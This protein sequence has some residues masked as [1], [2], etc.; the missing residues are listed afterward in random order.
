M[1]NIMRT[2]LGNLNRIYQLQGGNE[3]RF[4]AFITA[5]VVS[6]SPA[7]AAEFPTYRVFL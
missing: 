4:K 3:K 1:Q 6:L 7:K 5:R 2:E